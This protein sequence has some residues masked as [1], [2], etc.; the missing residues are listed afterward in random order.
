[1][2]VTQILISYNYVRSASAVNIAID[3]II[4]VIPIPELLKLSMN[5]KKKLGLLAIFSV[6]ILYG[7]IYVV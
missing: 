3:L 4:V 5:W 7:S 1:M 2:H 6:G